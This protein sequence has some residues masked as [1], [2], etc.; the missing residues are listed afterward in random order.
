[1]INALLEQEDLLPADDEKACTAV[2][3]EISF[4]PQDEPDRLYLAKIERITEEEWKT[5][6]EKLFQDISDSAQNKDGDDGEP[7][8]ERDMRIKAAFQKLKCVYPHIKSV[9]DLQTWKVEN[10]LAHPNVKGILGIGVPLA[11][12]SREEFSALIKPYIDSSNSK[13]RGGKSFAQWP[14]V[15]VVRLFIKSSI[16]KDGIVLVDLPGS[17]DTNAARGAIAENYTKN[18]TVSC[19][20]APT[21]RAASDKPVSS[22][23]SKA[24]TDDAKHSKA[25]DLLGNIAQRTMKLDNKFSS[26]HLCFIVTKTDSSL[27]MQR[28]IKTHPNV[29]ED[30]EEEFE[31]EKNCQDL[32]IQAQDFCTDRKQNQEDNEKRLVVVKSEMKKLAAAIRKLP[33]GSEAL[34]TKKRKVGAEGPPSKSNDPRRDMSTC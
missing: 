7:D 14:L 4:N 15:K 11:S 33:G 29:E 21:Q 27:N 17:M 10:L 31:K 16:L 24:D 26:N 2:C 19:I 3:V 8:L 25:Q 9:A 13:E 32:L 18:L 5:E 30:L 20:C 22:L 1:M 12:S 34:A 28:Y 6:L 23:L